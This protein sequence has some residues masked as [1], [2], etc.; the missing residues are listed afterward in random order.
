MT[1]A[2]SPAPG[3]GTGRLVLVAI[4]VVG[5]LLVVGALTADQRTARPY[6][7]ASTSPEGTHAVIELAERF[8]ARVQVAQGFPVDA[9]V[10]VAFE[11]VVPATRTDEV[12]RWVAAGHTLV[13]ADARSELTPPADVAVASL[14]GPVLRQG[15]CDIAALAAIGSLDLGRQAT[16]FRYLP[17]PGLSSCF[18]DD[19]GAFAVLRAEGSGGVVGLADG[20][21]FQNRNLGSADNAVLVTALLA[22]HP[23]VRVAI[24]TDAAFPGAPRDEDASVGNSLGRLITPSVRLL[25]LQLGVALAVFAVARGRRLGRPI[26]EPQPVQ[27]AGSALVGAVGNLL[28]QRRDPEPAANLLRADLR[29]T[30]AERVGLPAT[31]P[32]SVLAEAVSARTG[33]PAAELRDVLDD[34]PLAGDAELVSLAAQIDIVRQEV[35]HGRSP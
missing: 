30:V 17:A 8:G 9:D 18:A 7:P 10:A 12:R 31:A 4:V 5:A 19:D 6:D 13:M 21:V 34:R 25:L 23:G 27:I 2:G 35:L 15:R 26:L 1:A 14:S 29:R 22:P 11:D 16:R 33:R 3:R 28:Q 20:S 32:P 24:L